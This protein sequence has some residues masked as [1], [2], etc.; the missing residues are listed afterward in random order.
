MTALKEKEKEQE[1]K[2]GLPSRQVSVTDI[3]VLIRYYKELGYKVDRPNNDDESSLFDYIRGQPYIST[4]SSS[5]EEAE[6]KLKYYDDNA[7]HFTDKQLE[8]GK[9]RTL[10][11][12][13]KDEDIINNIRN[14]IADLDNDTWTR[15]LSRKRQEEYRTKNSK[16]KISVDINTFYDL[17]S[18][19]KRKF[20]NASWDDVF[21]KFIKASRMIDNMNK[22][23]TE[24]INN[25]DD[26]LKLLNS[27]FD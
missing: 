18:I 9:K 15:I 17:K 4:I 8:D 7:S 14:I 12:I 13:L 16:K 21:R 23:F 1:D 26:A 27:L 6:A 5:Q 24:D 11:Y 25:N 20:D 10:D 3:C 22:D 2:A 19:K